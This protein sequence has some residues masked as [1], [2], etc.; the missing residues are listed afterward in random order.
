[1]KQESYPLNYRV[2]QI[3]VPNSHACLGTF[4]EFLKVT[5]SFITSVHLSRWNKLAPIGLI[6]MKFDIY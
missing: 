1:M 6:F 5:V 2:Q 3:L 4:T